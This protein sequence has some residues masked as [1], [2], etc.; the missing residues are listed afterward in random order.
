MPN[1]CSLSKSIDNEHYPK[2]SIIKSN[3]VLDEL[4]I[5]LSNRLYMLIF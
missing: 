3:N 5:C 1:W 4:T 2:N